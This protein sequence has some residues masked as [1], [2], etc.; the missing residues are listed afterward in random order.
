VSAEVK[1]QRSDR[2]LALAQE[3]A[4]NFR[5]KFL[6]EVVTVLWEKQT[7]GIWSG[8]TDNY[9]RVYT[10]SDKDLINQLLPAKLVEVRG[11]GVWG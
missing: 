5:Q 3:S 6:G 2:M 8:L 4:R 9:I 1:K 11:D 10:R 7:K